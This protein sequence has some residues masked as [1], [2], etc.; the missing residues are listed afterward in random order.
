MI[1]FNKPC[2]SGNEMNYISDAIQR[3]KISGNGYYTEK[4]Q[5]IF[6]NKFGFNKVLLTHSCTDALEMAAILLNIVPGDEVIM[7]TYT[8]VSTANAFVLRGAKIIFADTEKDTPNIDTANL[9]QLITKNTKAIVVTHYGGIAAN[10]QAILELAAAHRLF[11]VEDAAAAIGSYYN[12]LPVGSI[13]HLATFSFHE[14]KNVQCGEGGMLVINDE[15]FISR[16]EIIWEKGTNRAAFSRKEVNR[17]QWLDIG[18]SFSP[19]EL[20]AA[21]LYGQLENFDDLLSARAK[22]WET[23]YSN[24]SEL[25]PKAF[26][27]IKIPDYA[28]QNHH[29][30]AILTIFG[31]ARE[32]LSKHLL[33]AGILAVSHYQC[34]HKS[35]YYDKQYVGPELPNSIAF[36]ENLLRLPIYPDL[37]LDEII[38]ICDRIKTFF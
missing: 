32:N 24:L 6:E 29:V 25:A 7:S 37:K 9:A 15:R 16:A 4:C 1:P 35:P 12:G 21:F 18:S 14:T 26:R 17:Y 20:N 19:S 10:M 34:L 23:Y 27:F 38:T 33:E 13:G 3:G 36:E 8:Y 5:T 28:G 11:I 22:Q 30:F 31:D 2:I